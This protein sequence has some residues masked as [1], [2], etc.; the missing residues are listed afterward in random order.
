MTLPNKRPIFIPTKREVALMLFSVA[1]GVWLWA[2][3][4]DWLDQRRPSEAQ[5][6]AA[7]AKDAGVLDLGAHRHDGEKGGR[8][9]DQERPGR[10][11]V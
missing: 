4:I 11:I 1:G 2:V 8:R 9:R 6:W 10:T 3:F 7:T 5:R